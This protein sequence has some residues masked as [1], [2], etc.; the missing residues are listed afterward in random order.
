M[1]KDN[2]MGYSS[3]KGAEKTKL[4]KGAWTEEEDNMLRK[5]V[6]EYGVGKWRLVPKRSGLHSY[7]ILARIVI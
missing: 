7:D 6:Q 4:R 5:C 1:Q 2:N 3:C